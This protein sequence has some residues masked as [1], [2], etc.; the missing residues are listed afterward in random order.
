MD[1]QIE[2]GMAG[3]ELVSAYSDELLEERLKSLQF[4]CQL[5]P[6][7]QIIQEQKIT[8]I[9]L[10]KI[11]V[12]KSELDVLRGIAADDW[13][14]IASIVMEVHD[15]ENRLQTVAQLLQSHGYRVEIQQDELYKG[16]VIYLVYANR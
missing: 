15:T 12:Q 16:S 5:R 7:S 13:N 4:S 3:M 14:K 10:M 11:D 8:H 2:S 1:N 6:L 9:D